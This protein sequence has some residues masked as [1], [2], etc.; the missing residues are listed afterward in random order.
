MPNNLESWLHRISE[1]EIPI[2]KHSV[3]SIAQVTQDDDSSTGELAQVILQDAS[4]TARILK[5]ANSV[6]YN[7]TGVHINTVSRAV[8]F[9]GF[10]KVRTISLS[11]AIIDALLKTKARKHVLKIMAESLHAAV[12]ARSFAEENNDESPEEVF[13]SALLYNLGEMAFWCVAGEEGEQILDLIENKNYSPEQAQQEVLGFTF[14]QLTAGLTQDWKLGDLLHSALNTPRLKNSRIQNITLSQELA[15][16][17]HKGW[18]SSE[19][20]NTINKIAQYL[21]LTEEKASSLTHLNAQLA[22]T[23]ARNFGAGMT[24]EYIPLPGAASEIDTP[25]ESESM[26]EY[27]QPDPML[28]LNIL[29]D[30]SSMLD[31]KPNPS[32][33]LEVA[34]EGIYRGIG[35]DRCLFAMLTPDKEML[36][37]KY[38]LGKDA[39]HFLHAFAISLKHQFTLFNLVLQKNSP[40]WIQDGRNS[41][42]KQCLP[43]KLLSIIESDHFFVSPVNI[44]NRVIG[45]FYADRKP[46]QRELDSNAY[47]SFKHFVQQA[48]LAISHISSAK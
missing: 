47:E 33:I 48:S 5:I 1:Q 15:K 29:R 46:S 16:N 37:G 45:L 6:A 9:I 14:N 22:V 13:I 44:N 30:L 42:Y 20:K 11:L 8:F 24:V 34:S 19:T 4:L 32:V 26:D 12:Q 31:A 36:R 3:T 2:F 38:A 23:T 18:R 28:Q 27:P 7:P 41:E 39:E 40:F 25:D 35:M 43:D 17:I 21:E 10:N